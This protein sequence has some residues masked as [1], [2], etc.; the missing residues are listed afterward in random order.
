M[1]K[2]ILPLGILLIFVGGV[3][4]VFATSQQTI[5]TWMVLVGVVR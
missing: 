2:L 4:S 3:T 1:K 5:P